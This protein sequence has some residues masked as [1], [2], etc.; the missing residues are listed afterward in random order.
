MTYQRL[1]WG[2]PLARP[3]SLYDIEQDIAELARRGNLRLRFDKVAL[4]VVRVLQS[5]L[6]E[7]VPEQ[8]AVLFTVSAPVKHPAKTIAALEILVRG[9]FSC[10]EI[11]DTVH[12]NKV[13]FRRVTGGSGRVPRVLGFVHNPETD[14]DLLLDLAESRLLASSPRSATSRVDSN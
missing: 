11:K 3:L 7:V 6:A 10:G 4:R 5:T 2:N 8:Q 9:S 14:P 13:R 1:T 12:G